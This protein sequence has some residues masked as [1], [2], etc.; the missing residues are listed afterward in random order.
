LRG[1]WLPTVMLGP[2]EPPAQHHACDQ[3]RR[4]DVRVSAHLEQR[5]YGPVSLDTARST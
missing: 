5:T 3:V 2:H 4:Q 1:G